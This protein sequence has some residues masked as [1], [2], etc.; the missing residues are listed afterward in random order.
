MIVILVTALCLAGAVSWLR[1]T[2][3]LVTV[4]GESMLPTLA[5]GERVLARRAR[6][7]GLNNGDLVV[8]RGEIPMPRRQGHEDTVG[9]P[10]WLIKRVAALPGDHIAQRRDAVPEGMVFLLGDNA[11]HSYDSRE[12]GYFALSHVRGKVVR[13]LGR[14]R[15][16]TPAG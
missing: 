12:A 10:C 8:I 13:R 4:S 16:D 6:S 5:P 1:R 7:A 9:V 3:T 2:F 11:A 15:G 14:H